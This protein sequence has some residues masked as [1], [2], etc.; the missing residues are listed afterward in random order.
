MIEKLAGWI[1]I[2]ALAIC[3]YENLAS[4]KDKYDVTAPNTLDELQCLYM[5]VL[6]ELWEEA[7]SHVRCWQENELYDEEPAEVTCVKCNEPFDADEMYVTGDDKVVCPDCAQR[8]PV[9]TNCERIF[10]ETENVSYGTNGDLC[11]ACDP[12]FDKIAYDDPIYDDP[13][14]DVP[15]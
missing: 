9:C 11:L 7:K 3:L 10:F 13:Y 2:N 14:G 1:D 5:G 12:D 6:D 4:A 8:L 15:L